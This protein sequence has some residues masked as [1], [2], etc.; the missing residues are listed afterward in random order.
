MKVRVI[1]QRLARFRI[2]LLPDGLG[3]YAE[4]KRN[5]V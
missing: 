2:L 1:L 5:K 3:S 4:K